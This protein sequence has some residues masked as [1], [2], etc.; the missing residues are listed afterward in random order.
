MSIVSS[1]QVRRT[2]VTK[3][4]TERRYKYQ[5]DTL[6]DQTARPIPAASFDIIKIRSASR[7]RFKIYL[8]N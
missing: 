4:T 2:D 3:V 1:L 7:R 6:N 5:I 8:G